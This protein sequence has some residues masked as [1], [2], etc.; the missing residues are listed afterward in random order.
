M[1]RELMR[2]ETQTSYVHQFIAQDKNFF[3]H[4][5]TGRLNGLVVYHKFTDAF[6][7]S[8]FIIGTWLKLAL[9]QGG[10]NDHYSLKLKF[11]KGRKQT[12]YFTLL[13]KCVEQL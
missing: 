9:A 8:Q 13:L 4:D 7:K 12:L 3:T 11:H 2:R 10:S 6:N 5:C 1:H